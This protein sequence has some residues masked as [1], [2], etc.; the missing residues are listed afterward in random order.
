MARPTA[1]QSLSI[2]SFS[3]LALNLSGC[4][5]GNNNYAP[6]NP[7]TLSGYYATQPLALSFFATVGGQTTSTAVSTDQIPARVAGIL[8]NPVALKLTDPTSG[9]AM[10]FTPIQPTDNYSI[11]FQSDNQTFGISGSYPPATLWTDPACTVTE[12]LEITG[13]VQPL[14]TTPNTT[15][16]QGVPFMLTGRLSID[17]WDEERFDGNCAPS[18][19]AMYNC[20]NDVTT[21]PG[22]SPLDQSGNQQYVLQ[23]FGAEIQ[24]GIMAP[25]DIPTALSTAY[26]V[27]YE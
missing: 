6:A 23:L 22:A 26:Q 27:S 13:R 5:L 4:R 10:L 8:T 9:A 19:Q 21:C 1:R 24:A 16:F 15:T 11:G 18:L 17:V 14:G 7:D 20:Y 3:L 25:Q 12:L 2:L